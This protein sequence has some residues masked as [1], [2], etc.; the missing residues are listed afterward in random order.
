MSTRNC[1]QCGDDDIVAIQ[2]ARAEQI[3]AYAAQ[4][5]AEADAAFGVEKETHDPSPNE[6][7]DWVILDSPVEEQPV[8]SPVERENKPVDVLAETFPQENPELQAKV[9]ESTTEVAE[10]VVEKKV[11]KTTTAKARQTPSKSS[12]NSK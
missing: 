2:K 5:V 9:D 12:N 6:I 8:V 1:Y 10:P 4:T 3:R 7:N 11:T